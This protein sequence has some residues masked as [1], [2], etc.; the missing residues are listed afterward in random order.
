VSLTG[1]SFAFFLPQLTE[2]TELSKSSIGAS[3]LGA[4]P[5]IQFELNRAVHDVL[6]E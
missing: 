6:D 5:T 2:R 4:W 1:E 3:F